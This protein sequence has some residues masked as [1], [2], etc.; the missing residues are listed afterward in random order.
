MLSQRVDSWITWRDD[1][2]PQSK[3]V[4]RVGIQ[5]FERLRAAAKQPAD[6][7][8]GRGDHG[9]RDDRSRRRSPS[10]SSSRGRDDKRL[11]HDDLRKAMDEHGAEQIRRYKDAINSAAREP[12][13]KRGLEEIDF[14]SRRDRRMGELPGCLRVALI[15]EKVATQQRQLRRLPHGI[16]TMRQSLDEAIRR[17]QTGMSCS[18][19]RGPQR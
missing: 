9:R 2:Q 16:H 11:S 3:D 1:E 14:D 8:S 12:S 13:I 4:A 10:R 18:L 15:S 17:Q 5:I 19:L 6:D 7:R